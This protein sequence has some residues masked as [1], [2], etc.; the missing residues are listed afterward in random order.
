[1]DDKKPKFYKDSQAG[2]VF[3][4]DLQKPSWNYI[5]VCEGIFD[6]I[7]IGGCAVMKNEINQQQLML[8][9]QLNK[10]IIIVPD[11]DSAGRNLI[12][13]ANE[14]KLYVSIPNW[15]NDVKD[16]ND[17]VM[18]YGRIAT[19]AMIMNNMTKN[20]IKIKMAEN[21]IKKKC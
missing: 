17:S 10:E 16:I 7:S 19:I 3:G 14:H 18:K 6:A 20:T 12:T 15:D 11:Q 4:I 5:I 8:L 2:Y 1:M 9:R 21:R 13:F